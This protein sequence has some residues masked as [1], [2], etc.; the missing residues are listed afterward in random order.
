MKM[1]NVSVL[2]WRHYQVRS[3][4][5]NTSNKH[6]NVPKDLDRYFSVLKKRMNKFDRFVYEMLLTG[7]FTVI[8]LVTWPRI[9]S[10]A[11]VTLF[12]YKPHFFSYVNEN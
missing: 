2:S 10:E 1:N 7:Q 4:W 12:W 11:G 6:R 5:T 3:N 8:C 9:E